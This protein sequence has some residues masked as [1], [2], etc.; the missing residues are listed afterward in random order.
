MDYDGNAGCAADSTY[1]AKQRE[2]ARYKDAQCKTSPPKEA[3]YD[4]GY[5][6]LAEPTTVR[7]LRRRIEELEKQRN[8]AEHKLSVCRELLSVFQG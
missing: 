2:E 3:Y 8:T 4:G 1:A 7:D 5:A 6:T